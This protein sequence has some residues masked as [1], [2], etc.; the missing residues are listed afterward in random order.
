MTWP[1][2]TVTL[3]PAYNPGGQ[4]PDLVRSLTAMGAAAIVVVDDGSGPAHAP[5]FA[6]LQG[7]PGVT[8]LR[9]GINLGKG[10]ALKTGFNHILLAWP[11]CRGVVTADADGQHLPQ[12]ILNLARELAG[13]TDDLVLGVRR[14]P[15]S[16]PLRSLIGNQLTRVIFALVVGR[17][18]QDTQTGLRGIGRELLPTLLQLEGERYE[19]EMNMLMAVKWHGATV[20]EVPIATVYED[21]NASS[22]FNPLLDSMK[23]YFLLCRF[24][25]SSLAASLADVVVFALAYRL[26]GT[27][28]AS[29][30]IGRFTVGPIVN[31]TINRTFVFHSRQ[32][33]RSTFCRYALA[34]VALG[35]L[36]STLIQLLMARSGLTPVAAKLAVE[37]ALFV[38]SF[39]VQRDFVFAGTG[40]TDARP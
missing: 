11:D 23:I 28:T 40:K 17:W 16:T 33:A 21:N 1:E 25:F 15:S 20:R 10:R 37:S 26:T 18:L 9:H 36:S 29:I 3:I 5:V 19:Y 39:A 34:A 30:L 13:T 35:M 38:V 2:K 4:L 14:F 24:L 32:R 7:I 31:Y 6:E 27:I 12:D 8:L 22:H